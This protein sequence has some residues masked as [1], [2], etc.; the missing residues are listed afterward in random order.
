MNIPWKKILVGIFVAIT[1][2]GMITTIMTYSETVSWYRYL[3]T[4]VIV[5]VTAGQFVIMWFVRP[6]LLSMSRVMNWSVFKIDVNLNLIGI[7]IPFVGPIY[8]ALL[9]LVLPVAVFIE[10]WFFRYG[11]LD[12]IDAWHRSV[13]FG[14]V[15]VLAGLKVVDG[16][17]IG[18]LGLLLSGLYFAGGLHLAWVSH[19]G[20]DL[21]GMGVL[22]IVSMKYTF[23]WLKQ[24][25]T[26]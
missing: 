7:V 5:A 14:F 9:V 15:H 25:R 3:T 11:T 24:R 20:F 1:T 23:S 18:F 16:I 8:G 2:L 6:K 12:W 13:V 10:E 22:I 19:L 26:R 21:I 17:L 4:T